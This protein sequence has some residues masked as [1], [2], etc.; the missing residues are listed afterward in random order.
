VATFLSSFKRKR[1]GGAGSRISAFRPPR[2]QTLP[3]FKLF[4]FNFNMFFGV[5]LMGN[6]LLKFHSPEPWKKFYLNTDNQVKKSVLSDVD[7]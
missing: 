2:L 1:A 6:V 4:S 5:C 7:G 3:D